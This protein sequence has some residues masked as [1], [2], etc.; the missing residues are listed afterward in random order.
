MEKA[1]VTLDTFMHKIVE[2]KKQELSQGGNEDESQKGDV[3]TR[4]VAAFDDAAKYGLTEEEVV[5]IHS[6]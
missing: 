5:S 6:F 1:W 4:L 3:F 2:E